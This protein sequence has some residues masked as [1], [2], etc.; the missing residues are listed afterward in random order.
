LSALVGKTLKD[1]YVLRR[2]GQ[3]AM[4]E[5]FLAQQ[6][7]LGRQVALK[8][9]NVDL[10]RDPTYVERFQHE[11][12]AAA[13][14]VHAG[15]VQIYEVGQTEFAPTNGGQANGGQSNGGSIVV[16]F[17]AQ[18]YVPGRNLGEVIRARGRLEPALVLDVLR[19]VSAA[20][21]KSSS[22]GIVHRDIKPEN[23]MLA[24]SGEVK[25]ADFGLARVQGGA[26]GVNLTQIGVTMGT[27]L[28]M[29]PEQIE[30]RALDSRSDIYSLGVTAYHML[31]GAPPFEGDTPLAVAMQHLNQTP[32]A[33]ETRR[34]DAP[35]EL[36]TFVLRMLAKKP[37]ERF[38]DPAAMLRELQELGRV[39]A[40]RGWAIAPRDW[41][42]SEMIAL[43]DD[44]SAAT[45]RLDELMKTASMATMV[46]PKKRRRLWAAVAAC[47]LAGG[48]V[49]FAM[50]PRSLLA[51]AADGPRPMGSVWAQLYQAKMV[52][53]LP[54]WQAVE[55]HFPDADP[56]YH[57]LAKQGLAN[58][59]LFRS[60]DYGRAVRELK[61][62]ADLGDAN[63]AL[64]AYGVA[65]LV[66]AEAKLG[67][68]ETAR[69]ELG[70]M[71]GVM[72]E[73]VQQRSPR[74]Y[75]EFEQTV[76]ELN[77]AG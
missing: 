28:Y 66:V 1:Y 77:S 74:L 25:V 16:H 36:S 61:D 58:Y 49:G 29:S 20:L 14:L 38:A 33:V 51:G 67:H 59:F 52:D 19:Q 15:I 30:G 12:R 7:S 23:I 75:E 62:L 17:I 68:L 6:L 37:E 71:D 65:G 60:Q 47:L 3:G 41:S 44:R 57:N 76:D 48:L 8:V 34:A 39:G 35:A 24:R 53:T 45:S 32:P 13:A 40:E 73:L 46:R 55:Q 56:Y 31:T 18:E 63:P 4:A 21:A 64:S 70:R 2:L 10:A 69:T 11:A 27:P 72:R 26:A 9:L 50:R 5:V 22:E 43:A 54:A 42:L